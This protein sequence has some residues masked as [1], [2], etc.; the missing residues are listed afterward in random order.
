V[1][2]AHG[3]L[4]AL[5]AA[6]ADARTFCPDLIA[7]VGDMVN[8]PSSAGVMDYLSAEGIGG[9]LGNH[10]EYV[11][12]CEEP[13]APPLWKTDRFAPAQWTRRSLTSEHLATLGTWPITRR[14]H[15]DV[16]LVHGTTRSLREDFRAET[17][18]RTVQ[19][20][21]EDLDAGVVA[22][23]H[24]HLALVRKIAGKLYVNVG[25]TGITL[26]DD[27]R[28]SYGLL[29]CRRGVWEAVI[30]RVPYSTTPV[31]VAARNDG[32]LSEGGGVAAAMVH[33]MLTGTNWTTPFLLWWG[34]TCPK[35]SSIDAYR[36]FAR[37]RQIEPLI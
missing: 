16:V 31:L 11:L 18:D 28:A 29:T 37:M 10:E 32:W 35:S 14:V 8:G 24:T 20:L 19:A 4:A 2:D 12:R 23:G 17:P 34:R 36:T 30:R 25:S 26:D 21:Y 13:D 7:H 27:P 15:P 22:V 33:E 3:N 5:E 6:L 1:S 9:V